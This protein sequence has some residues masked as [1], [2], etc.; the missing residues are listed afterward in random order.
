MFSYRG[1]IAFLLV[2]VVGIA[3]VSCAK[4]PET[5]APGPAPGPAP[6]PKPL[7][8]VGTEAA[9]APFEFVNEKTREI[10]G[11]DIDIIKAIA[12]AA[13]FRV[14]VKNIDWDGLIPA[15][16]LKEVDLVIS[17]MTITDERALSVTFSDPYFTTGQ[18][19]MTRQ[20]STIKQP[21]DLSGKRVGVQANT[22]GDIAA[23]RIEGATIKRFQTTPDAF[24]E[25]RNQGVDAVVAD[26][27]VILEYLQ[28]NPGAQLVAVGKPFT[29]E[30]YGIAMRQTDNELHT[31]INRGLAQ[32]KATGK[33][34]EI[35]E[36]WFG[37]R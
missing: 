26:E 13:G 10:E 19:I 3:A 34:D 33:Y 31:Q 22:T 25:L 28:A 4:A 24:N 2:F 1:F 35:Y 18:V 29:I 14:E 6:A 9:Y 37:K 23:S 21:S 36:K 12:E 30:Y 27:M 15:L 32:V 7:L 5:P 8:K 16:S 11:F 20:G 17:A